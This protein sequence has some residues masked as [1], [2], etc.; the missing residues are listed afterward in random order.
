MHIYEHM[1]VNSY[2]LPAQVKYF[3]LQARSDR[4]SSIDRSIPAPPLMLSFPFSG[5]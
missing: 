1:Y 3:T 5:D 2:V 4:C